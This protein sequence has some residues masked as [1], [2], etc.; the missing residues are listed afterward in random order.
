[1]VDFGFWQMRSLVTDVS[2]SI[3]IAN[4][5]QHSCFSGCHR[6]DAWVGV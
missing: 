4:R 1:V 2:R 3:L 5:G 6:R